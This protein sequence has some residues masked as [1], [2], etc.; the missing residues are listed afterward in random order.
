MNRDDTKS[1]DTNFDE[2]S[3]EDKRHDQLTTAPKSE[4]SDAA[5][6]VDITER[7]DGP[8]RIDVRDDAV[9]RPGKT[10][11]RDEKA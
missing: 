7:A 6:R 11:G 1:E 2:M 4:E 3:D 8:T 10:T 5:P 9:V